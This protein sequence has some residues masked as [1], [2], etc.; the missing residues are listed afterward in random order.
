MIRRNPVAILLAATMTAGAA[1]ARYALTAGY[2]WTFSETGTETANAIQ[3]DFRGY[4]VVAGN[5]T[6][7]ASASGTDLLVQVYSITH[8]GRPIGATEFDGGYRLNEGP[9]ALKL[10][11]RGSGGTYVTDVF[12]TFVAQTPGT[13]QLGV[14]YFQDYFTKTTTMYQD[15]GGDAVTAAPAVDMS[16]SSTP[17]FTGWI[18]AGGVDQMFLE[19]IPYNAVASPPFDRLHTVTATYWTGSLTLSVTG[20]AVA[21]NGDMTCWVVGQSGGD[22]ALF[23]Y[24]TNTYADPTPQDLKALIDPAYPR[25]FVTP[26]HDEPEAAVVDGLGNLWVAGSIDQDGAI[27]RFD[28]SGNPAAGFPVRF[29]RGSPSVLNGIAVTADRHAVAIGSAGG[30]LLVAGV[31]E[32]GAALTDLPLTDDPP[33]LGGTVEGRG[34]AVEADGSVWIA[35]T[36]RYGAGESAIRLW[37]YN[38][39]PDPPP[40]APGEVSVRGPEGGIL[41]LARNETVTILAL[42]QQPGDVRAQI[43]TP[44]GELVREFL[45]PGRGNELVTFRWDGRNRAG[46]LVASGMYAVR[47][48]GGEVTAVRRVVVIRK[49]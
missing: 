26:A 43:L 10:R 17:Y 2:P 36:W 14:V 37:R 7:P 39:T 41:N 3:L 11:P 8:T 6:R 28:A 49:R 5:I 21:V 27:W 33:P 29:N 34:I 16:S 9:P 30:S 46:E 19:R 20:R 22:V 47:V 32:T 12:T 1:R 40:I 25:V 38:F 24:T 48:T 18:T 13:P 42:P 35:G 15:A 4:A 44:R 45:Y 23:R 31:D